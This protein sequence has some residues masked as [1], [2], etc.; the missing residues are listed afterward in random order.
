MVKR[1][2][3]LLLFA[4]LFCSNSVCKPVFVSYDYNTGEK[5]VGHNIKVCANDTIS[6]RV[7]DDSTGNVL[8]TFNIRIYR[9]TENGSKEETYSGDRLFK[10]KQGERFWLYVDELFEYIPINNIGDI[11]YTSYHDTIHVMK[12]DIDTT[13]CEGDSICLSAYSITKQAGP[14][15]WSTYKYKYTDDMYGS[16]TKNSDPI[17]LSVWE[18]TTIKLEDKK[19]NTYFYNIDVTKKPTLTYEISRDCDRVELQINSTNTNSV[20]IYP[21]GLDNVVYLSDNALTFNVNQSFSYVYIAAKNGE[22]YVDDSV[23]FSSVDS[24]YR[25]A[26]EKKHINLCEDAILNLKELLNDPYSFV[27]YRVFGGE[28]DYTGTNNTND[29]VSFSK[30]GTYHVVVW[31]T[32]QNGCIDSA[33]SFVTVIPTPKFQLDANV[34]GLCLGDT[35]FIRARGMGEGPDENMYEIMHNGVPSYENFYSEIITEPGLK[36]YDVRVVNKDGC[37]TE[38]HAEFEFKDCNNQCVDDTVH[39]KA[40]S[41]DV[42]KNGTCDFSLLFT[43]KT[44]NGC[45]KYYFIDLDVEDCNGGNENVSIPLVVNGNTVNFESELSVEIFAA[46]GRKVFGGK[47]KSVKLD[48]GLYIVTSN[49]AYRK[50]LIK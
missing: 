26:P 43:S 25:I 3:M 19:G 45:L 30:P 8:D 1:L 36:M 10:F 16:I 38:E 18:P 9:E 44:D 17:C 37:F 15:Y 32:E 23:K 28:A 35:V 33:G 20:E 22:C 34:T 12:C 48:T 29:Y 14:F 27:S 13:V 11:I 31:S 49:G 42:I 2:L 5:L 7:E 40:A 47:C 46:D 21:N 50:V 6:L 41:V 4:A 39:F 24:R